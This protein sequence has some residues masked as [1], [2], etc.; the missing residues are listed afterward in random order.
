MKICTL[1]VAVA[2]SWIFL[3]LLYKTGF[4]HDQVLLA[5]LIGQSITGVFYLVQRKVARDLRIFS[6]PFFLTLTVIA[7]F[8]ITDFK[9]IFTPFGF[10]FALW[11]ISYLIFTNRNDPGK[12]PVV[13]EIVNCCPENS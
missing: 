7:Y 1:C 4:F 10:L 13:E 12:R 5:L 6:L 11:V 2:T 9:D 8:I 3:L